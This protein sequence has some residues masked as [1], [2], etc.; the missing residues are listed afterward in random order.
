[1]YSNKLLGLLFFFCL[2]ASSLWA[3]NQPF[4]VLDNYKAFESFDNTLG[5]DV[6]TGVQEMGALKDSLNAAVD[7][8]VTNGLKIDL[9]RFQISRLI[10]N[11]E[12]GSVSSSLEVIPESKRRIMNDYAEK[13][14]EEY[15]EL[16]PM[17][18]VISNMLTVDVE[19]ARLE[20]K[21]FRSLLPE[22]RRAVSQAPP[23]QRESKRTEL[24]NLK[25][26]IEE[27]KEEWLRLQFDQNQ[28]RYLEKE[29][30]ILPVLRGQPALFFDQQEED[31]KL[32]TLQSGSVFLAPNGGGISLTTELL[33]DY[34]LGGKLSV[35]AQVTDSEK[36]LTPGKV[37]EVIGGGGNLI[38]QHFLPLTGWQSPND[39]FGFKAYVDSRLAMDVPALDTNT[40]N[41]S[42]L[43]DAGPKV[44]AYYSGQKGNFAV[45]G[46]VRHS[47]LWGI[48][49]SF[50]EALSLADRDPKWL[51]QYEL[52]VYLTSNIRVG[53]AGY[54][55]RSS[56]LQ[57]AFPMFSFGLSINPTKD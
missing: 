15:H 5:E 47:V 6:L 46:G 55:S 7:S 36:E 2:S 4:N 57:E 54:L 14:K 32:A 45:Y 28:I 20:Y 9:D 33:N 50:A 52:G 16:F 17:R 30:P 27:K 56:R 35:L 48:G 3:Q 1:M 42:G 44:T 39:Q 18:A 38:L 24:S 43:V 25:G 53:G 29:L 19:Q 11:L 23:S 37:Q 10:R 21:A 41:L 12:V 13:Y 51:F 26:E 40:S 8:L 22:Y 34:I 31:T 49:S